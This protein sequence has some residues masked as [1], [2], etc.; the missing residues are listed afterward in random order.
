MHF[1]APPF[2]ALAH[3][4]GGCCMDTFTSGTPRPTSPYSTLHNLFF[5]AKY[6]NDIFVKRSLHCI[7]FLSICSFSYN[8]VCEVILKLSNSDIIVKK[9]PLIHITCPKW[10]LNHQLC[11]VTPLLKQALYT[12][13]TMAG[14]Q[15]GIFHLPQ[16]VFTLLCIL[17]NVGML[18]SF[19]S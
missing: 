6:C 1:C 12:Q 5:V 17:T 18:R 16:E 13:A 14:S 10:D 11:R 19:K 4:L 9:V 15:L 2:S 8:G 7:I 3:T